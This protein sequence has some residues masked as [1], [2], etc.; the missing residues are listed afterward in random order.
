MN[1]TVDEL[2]CRGKGMAHSV[3]MW[4]ITLIT[5]TCSPGLCNTAAEVRT[6]P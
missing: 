2:E 4:C 6:A 1:I 3:F 5:G